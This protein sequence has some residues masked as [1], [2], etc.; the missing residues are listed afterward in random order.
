MLASTDAIKLT[1]IVEKI[2]FYN[3]E[4]GYTVLSISVS[5]SQKDAIT[6]VGSAA[7]IT[8]GE[9]IQAQGHWVQNKRYG[10]QFHADLISSIPP[11]SLEGIEKYLSSGL[12]KGVGEVYAAKLIKAFGKD[13]L[14]VIEHHPERLAKVP[15]I[16][17]VRAEKIIKGWEEQ[18]AI[19]DIIIFVHEHDIPTSRAIRIFKYYGPQ[20]LSIIKSNPYKL[21]QDIPGIG[22]KTCD[23][24]A[25]KIGMLRD[26]P[27]RMQAG[28]NYS[29]SQA[30]EQAVCSM[31]QDELVKN[32]TALLE[33]EKE[34]IEQVL[35]AQLQKGDLVLYEIASKPC[36]FLRH[37]FDAETFIADRLKNLAASPLPWGVIDAQEAIECVEK[38]LEINLSNTQQVA[39]TQALQTK[40]LVITGGP[41]VGKT[42]IVNSILKILQSKGVKVGLAAPTGRAAKRIYETTG[43]EA[44]TLHRLLQKNIG[45]NQYANNVFMLDYDLLI[46]DEVSMVDVAL[47]F[48]LLRALP[49]GAALLLVGDVDQLPSVG[50]G[51]VLADIIGSNIF[52]VIRLTEIFRQVGSS[53]IITNAYR[54]NNA[55]VP[56]LINDDPQRSD[57]FFI[58]ANTSEQ[59]LDVISALVT[60]N[61]PNKFGISPLRDVQILSPMNKGALGVKNLNVVMQ[62]LLN[63]T[64]EKNVSILGTTF[65]VGDKVMQIENNYD[66]EVYNGDIGFIYSIEHASQEMSIYFDT[67]LLVYDFAELAEISLAYA[68]TIHKSQGSEYHTVIIPVVNEHFVMLQ[69][70]LLYTAV[71][72]GKKL[73]ILVGQQRAVELAV[74]KAS[75]VH[76]Y[77]SLKQKLANNF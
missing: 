5:G 42:T 23:A 4:N 10:A 66:K 76:R 26:A 28:I 33:I 50:P 40:L 43:C 61:I 59:A 63:P 16:G 67:R 22:F 25:L 37:I 30:L 77:S 72:R 12:I 3:Q 55:L 44:K 47:M 15:G 65:M 52:E 73:V 56:N 68:I 36:I 11:N 18:K 6:V 38:T 46:V 51:S 9:H 21:A 58:Q 20:A 7:S 60:K 45:Q 31:P 69:R 62:K 8:I 41:G 17:K 29:L 70:N 64:Q 14:N 24:I 1:G 53:K 13:I 34:K 54:I 74:A 39:V 32:T 57:F 27:F 75:Q 2:I 48:S 49:N 35:Q 71:T 19:R